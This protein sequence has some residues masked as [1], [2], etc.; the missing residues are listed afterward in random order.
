MT[1]DPFDPVVRDGRMYGR[2]SCDTKGGMAA[3]MHA[4]ASLADE[5]VIPPCD[6]W[7]AA[8]IDEEFSYRGVVAL[9]Q[10]LQADAAIVAEPTMLRAVVA[11]KGLVRW[12]IE[13]V[14]KA[15][16]SAKPHLGVNAIEHM[17]LVITALQQ[18]SH[19]TS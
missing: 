9:C 16:H 1:I 5:A 8:A 6:V 2:G 11:S 10:D 17:A 3:M 18:D 4:L 15:A 7:F 14:G 19:R 12:K 13:T